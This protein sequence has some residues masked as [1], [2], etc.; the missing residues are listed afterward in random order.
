MTGIQELQTRAGIALVSQA[1]A[2]AVRKQQSVVFSS[3]NLLGC[4]PNFS[5]TAIFQLLP[6]LNN[7]TWLE[8]QDVSSSNLVRMSDVVRCC[9]ALMVLEVFLKPDPSQYW[10]V[11]RCFWNL[12]D[13]K[14]CRLNLIRQH[15][16]RLI[17]KAANQVHLRMDAI[18]AVSDLQNSLA[19][20]TSGSLKVLED[21][22][23][24]HLLKFA[25]WMRAPAS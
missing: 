24:V 23:F 18:E 19:C 21:W 9:P 4:S 3:S 13:H 2:S 22:H 12:L 25:L 7:V 6:V 1:F 10:Q 15:L 8:L 17:F 5:T 14:S 20:I 11:I 16:H